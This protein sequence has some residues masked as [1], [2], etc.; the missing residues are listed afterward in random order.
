MRLIWLAAVIACGIVACA[1]PT[2]VSCPPGE[3]PCGNACVDVAADNANCGACGRSCAADA[4]CMAGMCMSTTI[5]ACAVGN[6]GCSADAFCMDIGGIAQCLCK[7]GFTGTGQTCSPCTM[8]GSGDFTS[9]PC[10]PTSDSV[11]SPCSQGCL[12]THYV[13]QSCGGNSDLVCTPCTQCGPGKYASMLC[14]GM[15]DTVCGDCAANCVQCA[16]PSQCFQCDVGYTLS[17]GMCNPPM[18]GNGILE[19]TEACDDNNPNAGDGCS[20]QCMV[21]VGSYCFGEGPSKCRAGAC[22]ASALTTAPSGDFV[23]DGTGTASASGFMFTTRSTIRT[24][25]NVAYPIL[26]EVD[27][28]YSGSDITFA[29]AR[30]PGTRDATNSD[31]PTDTLRARLTQSSGLM[32]L[33]EGTNTIAAGTNAGFTPALGVPYRVR[34]VD[35]G[36]TASVEWFNLTNLAQGAAVAVQ[37]SFHGMGDRAFVGGGDSSGVTM[38]NLRVCSAPMLPVTA[39]LVARYSAIPSWTIV[40]DPL[41]GVSQWQDGSGNGN[42]LTAPGAGPVFG[43][44]Y[45]NLQ[46]PGLSFSGA[47]QL[48][49]AAFALTTEVTVF[50]VIHHNT[51]A[52]WGAI[53]HHGSRDADWSME[54]NADS[55]DPNTLHWQTNNDNVNVNLTLASN[56]S[57]VMTGRLGNNLRYFSATAFSGSS[58]AGVSFTDV[59]QSI[60]AGSKQLFVGT[61]DNNEASNAFIGDI[62]YFNRALSDVE[63]DAV[64]AYLRGLWQP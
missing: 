29:G 1:Q 18:C 61:S 23:L 28:V 60:S 20:D 39:G 5:D 22:V 36:L 51:P 64:I 43:A 37:S 12:D 50:A 26:I 30:G 35:D 17:E 42:H 34:Y 14:N 47:T 48:V 8:C 40:S 21:E 19:G 9:T 15:Q 49:S 46:R 44:G 16:G 57:Y 25:Q 56:T 58:P 4:T 53:A 10:S 41:M 55:G 63:R 62:V 59:S 24:A 3:L 2:L 11:C 13:S 6:G 7:P 33:V 31:E 38:R 45:I 52:N 32:Q 27:V 54:Q